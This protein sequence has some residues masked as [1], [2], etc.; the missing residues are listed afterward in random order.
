MIYLISKIDF[1]VIGE[2]VQVMAN[3]AYA[4]TELQNKNVV[5]IAKECY[6]MLVNFY[7][8]VNLNVP[9]VGILKCE[10]NL[11]TYLFINP[12][13][14][15]SSSF[16][17]V[18]Y[19]NNKLEI[20]LGTNL[21]VSLNGNLILSKPVDN[22]TYSHYNLFDDVC[23]VFFKGKRKFVIIIEKSSLYYADYYDEINLAENELYILT[24]LLD[25]LNHGRVVNLINKKLDT[26]LVYLDNNKRDIKPEFLPIVF[27]DCLKAKNYNYCNELLSP[28]LKQTNAS[29]IS[30]FFC[31]F[32]DYYTLTNSA[33]AL[34]NENEIVA[35]Y[36]FEVENNKITNITELN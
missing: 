7:E 33:F 12:I 28:N 29:D 3:C 32:D 23:V 25:S 2:D 10:H 14:I 19:K 30:K 5:I 4:L 8:I 20:N 31:K 18:E 9:N 16:N 6:P 24:H 35:K 26:Y 22:L 27:L 13:K 1:L 21:L 17:L 34:I 11:N 36:N 15:N